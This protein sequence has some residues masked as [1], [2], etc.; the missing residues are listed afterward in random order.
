MFLWMESALSFHVHVLFLSFF[1]SLLKRLKLQKAFFTTAVCALLDSI[2]PGAAVFNR[3]E[4]TVMPAAVKFVSPSHRVPAA[5]R[6]QPRRCL[7]G[8]NVKNARPRTSMT[9]KR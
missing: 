9:A 6:V 7:H 3:A 1:L 4:N 2:A 8:D 5:A